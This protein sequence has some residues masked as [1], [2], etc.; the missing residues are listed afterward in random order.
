MYYIILILC[1]FLFVQEF[2]PMSGKKLNL[3]L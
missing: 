1:N 2:D 3:I